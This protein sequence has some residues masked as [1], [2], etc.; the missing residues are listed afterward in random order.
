MMNLINIK[1]KKNLFI[2]FYKKIEKLLH[3]M[4]DKL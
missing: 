1:N 4:L 2:F 3:T